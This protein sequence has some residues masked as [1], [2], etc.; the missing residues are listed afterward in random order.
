MAAPLAAVFPDRTT[1]FALASAPGAAGIAVWR[2]SGPQAAVAFQSLTGQALPHPRAMTRVE[3]HDSKGETIDD[4]LAAW[5]PGPA[6]F[7]GEDVFEL[8][9]HGGRAIAQAVT[10]A[11]GALTG[12]RAA[13]PGEFTRRAVEAGKMDLTGA[14]AIADLVAAET[15]AQ[16]RQARRQLGGALGELYSGWS[17]EI[18]GILAHFEAG[19]D[20]PD[21]EIPAQIFDLTRPRIEEL[22]RVMRTHLADNHLGERIREGIRVA[23]IGAPNVGKSSLVNAL[24]RREVAIV[25]GQPG[26]TRDIIE[27]ALDLDGV[28]VIVA[29]TAGLR[30]TVNEIEAEGIRRARAWAGE[31][32]IVIEVADAAMTVHDI[33][34]GSGADWRADGQIFDFKISSTNVIP[35][36]SDGPTAILAL[37]KVDLA[38]GARLK[39]ASLERPGMPVVFV[40]AQTGEGL[41]RL[42]HLLRARAFDFIERSNESAPLTR[43]RHRAGVESAADCLNRALQQQE[44]ELAG[45]E[46]RQAMR[47]LGQIT[48]T[49]G[50]EE[51]LEVIFREFCIGK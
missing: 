37:N 41:D 13:E 24:A 14:E 7:T 46:L 20:F 28:P 48:G 6:S 25:S 4:G 35:C 33:V 39:W 43:A 47:S 22:L 49:V 18:L 31:A 30:E 2:V 27:V 11:I 51:V 3:I 21:E 26:T 8:Y 23:V 32:D 10:G 15:E 17:K 44:V 36:K 9:L 45:E 40:S 38:P 12:L 50:V 29:D 16:R 5:F 19:M 42:I 34:S 1:I